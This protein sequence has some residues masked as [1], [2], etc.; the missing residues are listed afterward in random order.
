MENSATSTT[1]ASPQSMD[2]NK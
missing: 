2:Q 1:S